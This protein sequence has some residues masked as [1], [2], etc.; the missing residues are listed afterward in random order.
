MSNKSTTSLQ[1]NFKTMANQN[2]APPA[3]TEFDNLEYLRGVNPQVKCG[4]RWCN[5]DVTTASRF[6]SICSDP[7]S[8]THDERGMGEYG[9]V[10]RFLIKQKCIDNKMRNIEME[11]QKPTLNTIYKYLGFAPNNK[12]D[13]VF[14]VRMKW[15][16]ET[17][18]FIYLYNKKMDKILNGGFTLSDTHLAI[19]SC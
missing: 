18:G 13:D 10:A 9:R 3:Y 8:K 5:L 4:R 11:F 14:Y 7:E 15:D 1:D 16:M 2:D 12:K 6:C 17:C 19:Y